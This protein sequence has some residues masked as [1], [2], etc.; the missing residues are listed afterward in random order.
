MP[1]FVESIHR[2]SNFGVGF[3]EQHLAG[4]TAYGQLTWRG[5][6]YPAPKAWLHGQDCMP[7]AI[8]VPDVSTAI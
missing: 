5:Q 4:V 3:G 6:S 7:G 8:G 1:P 2:K